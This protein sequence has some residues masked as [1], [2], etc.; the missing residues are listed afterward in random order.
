MSSEKDT[1]FIELIEGNT[2]PETHVLR[3]KAHS[4]FMIS[5]HGAFQ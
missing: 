3:E 4:P 1:S 5:K 2:G